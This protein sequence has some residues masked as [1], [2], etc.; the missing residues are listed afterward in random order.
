MVKE[1]KEHVESLILHST[2][3]LISLH[4]Q[5]FGDEY[6]ER[7]G[8]FDFDG[9]EIIRYNSYKYLPNSFDYRIEL[10]F[11]LVSN[12]SFDM[13]SLSYSS[14]FDRNQI[15]RFIMVGVKRE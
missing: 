8:Y 12:K 15:N 11:A 9:M 14:I 4:Q 10:G 5:I 2:K 13:D 3:V 6:H 1:F 7:E